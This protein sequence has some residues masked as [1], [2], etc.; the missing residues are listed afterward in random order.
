M[1]T[2][3]ILPWQVEPIATANNGE[4]LTTA[5][6]ESDY[7]RHEWDRDGILTDGNEFFLHSQDDNGG[8]TTLKDLEAQLGTAS[9]VTRWRQAHPDLAGT[10]KDCVKEMITK[11]KRAMG[12]NAE[13]NPK[14]KV[15]AAAVLLLFKRR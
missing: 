8:E 14:I 9:M 3:L 5:F 6:P 2:N 7:I 4:A 12:V 13:D 15:A 11:I 1:Y 10:E